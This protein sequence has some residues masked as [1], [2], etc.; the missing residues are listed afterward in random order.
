MIRDTTPVWARR[1][2]SE[3]GGTPQMRMRTAIAAGVATGAAALVLGAVALTASGPSK[4]VASSHREAPLIANDPTADLTDFYL[5]PSPEKAGTVTMI[6]NVIPLEAPPEGPNYYNLDDSARYR[7]NIDWNGDGKAERTW[8][9]RTKTTTAY[10]GTFLYNIGPVNS[11]DDPNLSVRQT[12][13]LWSQKGDGPSVKIGEGTTAPNNVGKNSFP[14]YEAVRQQAITTLAGGTRVYVGPSEDPFAIDVGRIFDLIGVGGKGTDNLAGF[15]VHSIA[16]QVPLSQIRQS[17]KQ[18]VIGG[19]AAVDRMVAGKS[20][21][22][23]LAKRST[24]AKKSKKHP[25]R[26][27]A[28]HWVQVERLGQPLINEVIIPRGLK[29]YW[30]SV[31]PDKDYQFEKYYT[32]QNKPGQLINALN[33]LLLKPLLTGVLGSPPAA[34][35]PTGLAQETGRADLSA[36]LLRGFKYPND[37]KA[38]LDLTFGKGDAGKPVDELRLNTAIP[39][40]PSDRVDRRGLMCNFAGAGGF[41]ALTGPAC[42]PAQFDGYPNGR[43]L[44]DDVT[45]IEIGALIGVPIDHLIPAGIQRAYALLALGGPNLPDTGP[46]S[47]LK[48]GADGVLVNDA[49]GGLFGNAFPYLNSPNS[50]N[51]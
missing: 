3:Q 35:G 11:I 6:A 8:T 18:P 26:A 37:S 32:D 20:D 4:A 39:G 27:S 40:T 28:K 29:D 30:N 38:A 9:L 12:W 36:I 14:N 31:G 50:G 48:F 13:T 44:G 25:A 1:Q 45:D 7:F 42:S 5:F 46:V 10:P 23:S 41:P 33:G 34:T 49:N 21:A 51:R 24:A 22:S 19:W 16:I 15:N 2:T 47:A 43:R 17:D